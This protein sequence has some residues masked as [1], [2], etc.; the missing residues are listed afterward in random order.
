MKSGERSASEAASA[1]LSVC[2]R[3]CVFASLCM[4]RCLCRL[5]TYTAGI[6]DTLLNSAPIETVLGATGAHARNYLSF[7]VM[8]NASHFRESFK[9]I[10]K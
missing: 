8:G 3:V 10:Q 2:A 4:R 5:A 1:C 6:R 7:L 9:F